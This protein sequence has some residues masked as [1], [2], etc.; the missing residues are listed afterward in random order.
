M[1]SSSSSL[2]PLFLGFWSDRSQ[3]AL[4]HS[5][6]MRLSLLLCKKVFRGVFFIVDFFCLFVMN[7]DSAAA[8]SF[9]KT[10]SGGGFGCTTISSYKASFQPVADGPSGIKKRDF[11]QKHIIGCFIKYY[12][13]LPWL[14]LHWYLTKSLLYGISLFLTMKRNAVPRRALRQLED[15]SQTSWSSTHPHTQQLSVLTVTISAVTACVFIY[16]CEC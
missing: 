11:H 15:H 8:A 9:F 3:V 16:V 6:K 7:G 4:S 12:C 5:Y 14:G 10:S 1:F 2:Y 13:L